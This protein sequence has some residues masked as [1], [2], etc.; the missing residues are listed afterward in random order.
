MPGI[1]HNAQFSAD[2]DFV[3]YLDGPGIHVAEEIPVPLG[4]IYTDVISPLPVDV[5]AGFRNHS[6]GLDDT[7]NGAND[8]FAA[9]PYDIKAAVGG[10]I[11]PA[12]LCSCPQISAS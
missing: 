7:R 4:L 5:A 1:A 2:L 6:G 8:I 11:S 9:Q 10:A 3:S 12:L